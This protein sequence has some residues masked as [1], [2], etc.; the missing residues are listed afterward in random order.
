[1]TTAD[2]L[3]GVQSEHP[4]M[5]DI[6]LDQLAIDACRHGLMIW[7]KAD[8]T[9]GRSL[10]LYT[11]APISYGFALRGMPYWSYSPVSLNSAEALAV[12]CV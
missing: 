7:P 3:L 12:L 6:R 4:D 9:I 5:T 10:G 1:M 2:D 11:A 8:E